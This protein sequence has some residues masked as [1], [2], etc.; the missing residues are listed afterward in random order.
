MLLAFDRQDKVVGVVNQRMT[1]GMSQ[2][3]YEQARTTGIPYTG[4]IP[5]R[6][7]AERL[8]VIVY[9]YDSDRLGVTSVPV[10]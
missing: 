2:A 6:A 10:R 3:L 4:T 5:V 7:V 8:K 9:N 1:L